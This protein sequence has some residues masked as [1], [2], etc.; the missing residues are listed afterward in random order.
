[1]G[2]L[3]GI[4]PANLLPSRFCTSNTRKVFSLNAKFNPTR[5]EEDDALFRFAITRASLRF[6]ETI[7]PEPLFIDT[8]S[9]CFGP[10]AELDTEQHHNHYCLATKFIDDRLLTEV[11]NID[12]V[13]Q[14]VLLTDGMDT[15]PYRLN[16]PKSTVVFDI[17]PDNVFKRAAQKLEDVGAKISK[18]CLLIHVPEQSSNMEQ[19][20]SK[21][22]TGNTPSLWVYQGFPVI[23]LEHFKQ[24]LSLVSSLAMKG[25]LFLGEMPVWLAE[26]EIGMKC[27]RN[28]WLDKLFM[29]YGFKVNIIAHDEVART[30]SKNLVPGEYNSLLFVAEHLRFSDDQMETWRG[31]YQRLEEEADEEGFEEL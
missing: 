27:T 21:G 28:E 17:S 25:C 9:A 31:V 8:Y 13:K 2:C 12:G 16:W 3:A 5:P 29:T 24:T 22:F 30:Y 15:R 20:C 14:V 10:T 11:K 1:M 18:N 6:K 26:T 23:N 4:S 19:L 7:S